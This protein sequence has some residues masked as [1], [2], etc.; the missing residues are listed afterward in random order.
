MT[1]KISYKIYKR[2]PV[3]PDTNLVNPVKKTLR[4]LRRYSSLIFYKFG[5][6][7]IA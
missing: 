4:V 2:F 1:N 6:K 3:N 5:S 7:Q